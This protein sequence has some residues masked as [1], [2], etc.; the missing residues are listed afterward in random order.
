MTF[1]PEASSETLAVFIVDALVTAGIVS[2]KDI[3]K[4]VA[5]TKEEIDVRKALG[6]YWCT[7]CDYRN[8]LQY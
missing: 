5:V 7:R 8:K 2:K 3:A 4:A 1:D 6:D